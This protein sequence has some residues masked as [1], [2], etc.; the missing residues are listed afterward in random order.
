MDAVLTL[1]IRIYTLIISLCMKVEDGRE[2]KVVL[3]LDA[4]RY[5]IIH[6]FTV[7]ELVSHEC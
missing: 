1:Y 6:S 7:N 2:M 3:N 5:C 4:P